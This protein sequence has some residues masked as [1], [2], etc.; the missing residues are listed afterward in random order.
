[1]GFNNKGLLGQYKNFSFYSVED[2]KL[3]GVGRLLR[4]VTPSVL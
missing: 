2:W 4:E 3:L 1:M